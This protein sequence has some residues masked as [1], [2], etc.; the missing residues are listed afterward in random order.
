M[1]TS[2]V[3]GPRRCNLVLIDDML[4]TTDVTQ[5]H[6]E[7]PIRI[8][9]LWILWIVANLYYLAISPHFPRRITPTKL[10]LNRASPITH[11]HSYDEISTSAPI[12]GC[13]ASNQ[14]DHLY[15]LCL[16][17]CYQADALKFYF[18]SVILPP[19]PITPL[20]LSSTVLPIPALLLSRL[21]GSLTFCKAAIS[22][23]T[24]QC[25]GPRS[26]F[27]IYWVHSQYFDCLLR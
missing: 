5:L 8:S 24:R 3:H 19:L 6:H 10:E 17:V 23:V 7:G 18:A 16:P 14:S 9:G 25:I 2:T 26:S 1:E 22:R 21:Q 15:E 4:T 13:F 12:T 11:F 20:P 27:D